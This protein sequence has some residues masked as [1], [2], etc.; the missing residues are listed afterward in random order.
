MRSHRMVHWHTNMKTKKERLGW[1]VGKS[2]QSGPLKWKSVQGGSLKWKSIQSGSLKWK[3]IQSGS[4]K[5][6]SIQCGSL[7]GLADRIDGRETCEGLR[8]YQVVH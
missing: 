2:I 5:W 4:L 1:E 3:S 8:V 7:M 6:K